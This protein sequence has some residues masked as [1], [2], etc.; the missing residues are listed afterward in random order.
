MTGDLNETTPQRPVA[1]IVHNPVKVPVEKL[2]HAVEQAEAHH[3]WAPSLWFETAADDSG[4]Q[5]ARDAAKERPDVIL[6]AGGDG[7]VRAVAEAMHES[8][9]PLALLPI[10][11]AN[12]LAR[13][14]RLPRTGI[15][16]A[17][18]AAFTGTDRAVDIA[19]AAMRAPDGT[20]TRKAYL[21]MAGIGLDARMAADATPELKRR[22]GWG[23]YVDPIARSII[24]NA[25]F[26]LRYRIDRGRSRPLR[27]HTIIVGNVGTLTAGLLLLPDAVVDDGLLDVVVFKPKGAW[28]WTQIASRFTTNGMF[29]ASRAGR[30]VLRRTPDLRALRYAQAERFEARF[31]EPQLLQLDGDTV[32]EVVGVALS[33]KHHGLTLRMPAA[34]GR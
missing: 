23:A 20:V 28:G 10:G 22:F 9:I 1:A 3:G 30:W 12:L 6:V 14:L 25:K 7:T 2:R 33:V 34:R 29:Q 18:A 19:F 5:A 27:A 16:R 24:G 26:D 17:V 4:A 15:P 31:D 8:G 32:G 13:N 21:V 11:T